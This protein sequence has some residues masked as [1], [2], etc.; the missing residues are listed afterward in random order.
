MKTMLSL[1]FV[2]ML[3]LGAAVAFVV[4]IMAVMVLSPLIAQLDAMA[5]RK[6]YG[7]D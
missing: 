2:I 3:A 7:P 6:S 5:F 4:L 1:P